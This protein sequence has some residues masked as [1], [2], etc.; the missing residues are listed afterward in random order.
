MNVEVPTHT[1]F[2][3]SN[4]EQQLTRIEMARLSWKDSWYNDFKR[5]EFNSNE[6]RVFCKLCRDNQAKNVFANAGSVNNKV[7][8]FVKHQISKEYKKLAW[9][10]QK[11][12]KVIEKM[13]HQVTKSCDEALLILF[14]AVY[15]LD[16]E[17]IPFL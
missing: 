2:S 16:R 12:Q 15:Y 10:A 9:V 17:I 14:R 8:A 4:C 3:T 11:G 5:I 6:G 1:V 7:S 13:M